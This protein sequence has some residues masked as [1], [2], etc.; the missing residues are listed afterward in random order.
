[1]RIRY[2]DAVDI[3]VEYPHDLPPRFPSR[4]CC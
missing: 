3:R 4:R 1:M 2:T